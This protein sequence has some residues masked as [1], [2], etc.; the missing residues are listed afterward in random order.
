MRALA[1]ALVALVSVASGCATST[2]PDFEVRIDSDYKHKREGDGEL[3]DAH[4]YGHGILIDERHVLTVAHVAPGPRRYRVSRA[5]AHGPRGSRVSYVSAT[6]LGTFRQ[7]ASVEPLVVLRLSRKMP[8]SLYPEVR[9]IEPGDSG[10]P[11]YGKRGAVVGL[12]T[13]YTEGGWIGPGRTILGTNAPN[14]PIP[15]V[16]PRRRKKQTK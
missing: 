1:C 10:S 2:A 15:R 4:S 7:G 9:G 14:G 16:F 8:C 13:G 12:I 6:Y 3:V 11:I 5:S